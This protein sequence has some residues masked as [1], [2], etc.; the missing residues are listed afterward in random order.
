[1]CADVLG[2][3][4]SSASPT[5]QAHLLAPSLPPLTIG[6]AQIVHSCGPYGNDCG[7]GL[8]LPSKSVR[9]S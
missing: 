2:Q 9:L 3:R 5:P 8:S 6:V 7:T 4:P 1:M